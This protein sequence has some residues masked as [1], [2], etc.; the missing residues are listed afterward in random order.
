MNSS[1]LPFQ[2]AISG[3]EHNGDV[4]DQDLLSIRSAVLDVLFRAIRSYSA[5][6]SLAAVSLAAPEGLLPV[7]RARSDQVVQNFVSSGAPSELSSM[8]AKFKGHG[9]EQALTDAQNAIAGACIVFSHSLADGGIQEFCLLAAN[10][11]MKYWSKVAA[12]RTFTIESLVRRG[13]ADILRTAVR[14]KITTMSLPS[15]MRYLLQQAGPHSK[16]DYPL[17]SYDKERLA[18]F[19]SLRHKIVHG[20]GITLSIPTKDSPEYFFN[21]T[22]YA[23]LVTSSLL[24]LGITYPHIFFE[25]VQSVIRQPQNGPTV[26]SS[27]E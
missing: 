7:F 24:G 23:G 21:L 27:R 18:E 10:F 20:E 12:N 1:G 15:K 14:A 26:P 16:V 17:F 11:D 22:I 4:T 9:D 6:S 3:K 5:T 8:M 19:D 25:W 13:E 2:I